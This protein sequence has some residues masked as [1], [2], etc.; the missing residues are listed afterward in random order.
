MSKPMT[1]ESAREF[2]EPQGFTVIAPETPEPTNLMAIVRDAEGYLWFRSVWFRSVWFRPA[3]HDN[4][5]E[6]VV[7]GVWRSWSDLPQ[8]VEVLFEGVEG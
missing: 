2:L 1:I 3:K 4:R 5:W 7:D 8:P 6:R